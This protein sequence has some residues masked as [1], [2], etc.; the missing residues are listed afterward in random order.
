MRATATAKEINAFALVFS[1]TS[2]KITDPGFWDGGI[3]LADR[4]VAEVERLSERFGSIV[5]SAAQ[6]R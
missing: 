2:E 5:S 4:L 6:P 1:I 3:K